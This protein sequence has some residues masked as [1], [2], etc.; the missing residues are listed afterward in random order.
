MAQPKHLAIPQAKTHATGLA[1]LIRALSPNKPGLSLENAPLFE[2]TFWD[3]RF[4]FLCPL[5]TFKQKNPNAWKQDLRPFINTRSLEQ[6]TG[7]DHKIF[8]QITAYFGEWNLTGGAHKSLGK[9]ELF[10]TALCVEPTTRKRVGDIRELS[11]ASPWLCDLY[12]S[13]MTYLGQ[14]GFLPTS[15]SDFLEVVFNDKETAETLAQSRNFDIQ[16]YSH[17]AGIC[18]YC[19]PFENFMDYFFPLSAHDMVLLSFKVNLD[20]NADPTEANSILRKASA[21]AKD[22]VQTVKIQEGSNFT[23]RSLDRYIRP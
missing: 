2:I 15:N 12:R 5:S 23:D 10:F 18:F 3:T 20:Q 4:T 14:L 22:L 11:L 13:K 1:R 17:S 6:Y 16:P 19:K 7:G 9:L 21:F 8:R